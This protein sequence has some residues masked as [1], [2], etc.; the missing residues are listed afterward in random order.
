MNE[1]AET[2]IRDTAER[3]GWT[4][5]QLSR[6]I[7]MNPDYLRKTILSGAEHCAIAR[8][9]GI[10]PVPDDLMRWAEEENGKPRRGGCTRTPANRAP[11]DAHQ[12]PTP[13]PQPRRWA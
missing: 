5:S 12:Y 3:M 4:L 9:K 11:L 10:I 13:H 1:I 7:G 6:R 2:W 8:M